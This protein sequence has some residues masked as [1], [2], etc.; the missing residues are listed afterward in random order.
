MNSKLQAMI[1]VAGAITIG[2][3]IFAMFVPRLPTTTVDELKDAGIADGQKIVLSCPERLTK[4]TVRRINSIQPGRLRKNQLVARV[5]RIANCFNPDGG[6]CF[7]PLD[8]SVQVS[9]LEGSIIVPSRRA[10]LN[11]VDLDA[12]ISAGTDTADS[13]DVDDSMTIDTTACVATKCASYD[14]GGLGLPWTN[15]CG[16]QN[17][18]WVEPPPCALPMCWFTAGAV[19]IATPGTWDDNAGAPGHNPAPDCKTTRTLDGGAVWG[20]CNVIQGAFAVGTQCLPV[21]CSVLA[22]DDA[23][24]ALGGL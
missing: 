14:A 4:Q 12:G 15:P 17:R 16:G 20:G 22:G 21:E 19:D 7:K 3:T 9:S 5:A 18:L 1:A 6:N 23:V 24:Q 2:S 13:N 11:G 10:N 8:W